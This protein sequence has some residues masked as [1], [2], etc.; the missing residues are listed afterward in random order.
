MP[1]SFDL[2]VHRI[3]LPLLGAGVSTLGLLAAC[4]TAPPPD[5]PTQVH[6]P[7]IIH[8]AVVP[9]EGVITELPPGGFVV[10]VHLDDPTG[11]CQFSVLVDGTAVPRLCAQSC[12]QAAFDG[13][14][15]DILLG[16]GLSQPDPTICHTITAIVASQFAVV[17]G[18][19]VNSCSTPSGAGGDVVT[20]QLWSPSCLT[21]DAGVLADGAFP[22]PDGSPDAL[23]IV[24][25]SGI[26]P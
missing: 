6:R 4:F 13:G 24:P 10:P 25:E 8:D 26:D 21:Y 23:P 22:F 3:L 12:S 11:P 1:R 19:N 5:L 17:E 7:E 2:R 16:F 15:G 9:P 18:A 14:G 20:W